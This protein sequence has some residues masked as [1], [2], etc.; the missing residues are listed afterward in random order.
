MM[1]SWYWCCWCYGA[2]G[3]VVMVVVLSWR[4]WWYCDGVGGGGVMALS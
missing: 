1:L 4:Y 2:R 3:G